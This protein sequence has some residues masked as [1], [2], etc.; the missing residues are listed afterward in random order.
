MM[1]LIVNNNGV[2]N[3][4]STNVSIGGKVTVGGTLKNTGKIQVYENG[5]LKV[6]KELINKGSLLI[7]DPE[8]IKTLLI[9]T[10]KTAGTAAELGKKVLNVFFGIK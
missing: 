8:K 2:T 7:N 9:E 4:E 3:T 10:V 1:T 5:E 6:S